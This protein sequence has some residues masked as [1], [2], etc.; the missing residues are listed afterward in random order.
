MNTTTINGVRITLFGHASVMF[1]YQG[2][3]IYV[4][5]YVL[6]PAP[7][8]A[9]LILHTHKHFDHCVLPASIMTPSTTVIGRGCKH[10]AQSAEIGS[11]M[12][13]GSLTIQ[14]VHAY[15]IGKPF[16]PKGEGA[17]YI[18]SFATSAGTLRIY[19]AGDTDRIPEMTS[20]KCDVAILPVGGTY[21][22]DM[23]EA[24]SAVVDIKPKVVIPYHCNYLSDTKVDLTLFKQ[25][26]AEKAKGV[27]VR[28]LAP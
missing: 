5:P 20:Y 18:F 2:Q 28:I 9:S 23:E 27:D 11:V 17:G 22:M 8:P 21:T 6:G 3:F 12:K 14:P 15:N 19:V 16:H 4:D 13:F 24:A 25:M 26:A 10:P 1:E 7:R